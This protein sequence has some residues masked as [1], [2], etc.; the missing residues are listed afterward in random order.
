MKTPIAA[1][2][3]LAALF[4]TAAQAYDS[5]PSLQQQREKIGDNMVRDRTGAPPAET[6]DNRQP[7]TSPDLQPENDQS[8]PRSTINSPARQERSATPS[9]SQQPSKPAS[10]VPAGDG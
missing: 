6:G 1:V 5:S 2:V 7:Q 8:R 9:G 3:L 4:I 10:G